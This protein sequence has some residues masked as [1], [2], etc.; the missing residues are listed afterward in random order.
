MNYAVNREEYILLTHNGL[1]QANQ[2]YV[3]P[4]VRGVDGEYGTEYPLEAF[5]LQGDMDKAKEYLDTALS[6]LGLSSASDISLKLVVSDSDTAKKEAEVVA[7]QWKNNLGINVD[8]N[9][10]PYA[11]KNALLV[12]DSDEY[13]IIMSGWAP[14]YSDPYS[15]LELWYST[16]GY[17]CKLPQ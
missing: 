6:E 10:V 1:Y 5:P 13:D 12:P 14:D 15:Y 17:N 16:S 3:L 4:Q 8:I 11:T 9:M 7:N 2:R